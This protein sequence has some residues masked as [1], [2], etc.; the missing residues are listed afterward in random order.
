[1]D[2]LMDELEVVVEPYCAYAQN[3]S[4]SYHVQSAAHCFGWIGYD[5][6]AATCNNPKKR[7]KVLKSAGRGHDCYAAHHGALG[8][9][10]AQAAKF[11]EENFVVE[12]ELGS[13]SCSGYANAM[14]ASCKRTLKYLKCEE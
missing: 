3:C 1:M 5:D 12:V 14:T 13:C 4:C 10:N 9:L 8:S 11:A 7:I 6:E 2:Q